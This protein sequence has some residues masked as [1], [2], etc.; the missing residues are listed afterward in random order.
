MWWNR[1]IWLLA[2]LFAIPILWPELLIKRHVKAPN[3][4]AALGHTTQSKKGF[5]RLSRLRAIAV[6]AAILALAGTVVFI[7]TKNRRIV[8]LLDLSASIS[9]AQVEVSRR[10]LL[11]LLGRLNPGDRAAVVTFASEPQLTAAFETPQRLGALLKTAELKAPRTGATN[12]EAAVRLGSRMLGDAG[13]NRCLLLLSDG[14]PTAGGTDLAAMARDAGIPIYTLGVGSGGGSL[15]T[16]ELKVPEV[17]H[18]RERVLVRWEVDSDRER[19]VIATIRLNQRTIGR[20]RVRLTAG[21]NTVLLPVQVQEPGIHRFE[22][23]VSDAAGKIQSQASSA[24]LLQ[25]TGPARVLVIHG[26]SSNSP[27]TRV[28]TTQ[29]MEVTRQGAAGIPENS[30]GLVGYGAV[31]LD[32]VPALYINEAQ[33]NALQG[34]VAGGGGLLVVGGDASLGRGEYYATG[35][36][37]L[38]PV[39]TDTRQRLFFNRANIL[40]VID[41]SGSMSEMVG[42]TSKQ[43]AAMQG[44][45]AA[46]EELNPQDQVGILSF[47]VEATWVLRF[48]P[49]RQKNLIR[50]ALSRIGQGGG[51]DMSTAMEE[52]V[53]GFATV[54]PVR[55]HVVILSDGQTNNAD[56]NRICRKLK[57]LGVTI[58]TIGIGEEVNEPL[59]KDIARWG[60][61]Q[62]YRAQLDQIPKV[63]RKETVR[64]TRDLI[65]EGIFYPQIKTSAP[66]LA[67]TAWNR[68]PVKGYLI[69]KPKSLATVFLGIGKNDPLL[70]SWRY[71]NGKVAVFTSDSGNRW[72]A[73]WSG[74]SNYNQLW[75]QTIRSV[76]RA[77]I[78]TGLMVT[79]RAEAATAVVAVE[80]IGTDRRLR[81]GLQLT[82]TAMD[83]PQTGTTN[84]E[85]GNSTGDNFVFTETAPGH[86]EAKV[87]L[88]SSGL[89][90]F[91]VREEQS[92]DWSVGWLWNPPGL[93]MLSSGPDRAFLENIA[94]ATGGGLLTVANPVLPTPGWAWRKVS[95]HN[96]LILFALLCFLTE[97]G[98]RSTSLGQVTMARAVFSAWWEGQRR[99]IEMIRGG[100]KESEEREKQSRDNI[101]EAY[102]YLAERARRQREEEQ[103]NA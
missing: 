60:D 48:T 16:R 46:I 58:T 4:E 98:I 8:A 102:R 73:A 5:R 90:Q 23:Q 14:R 21:R 33:Q 12:L 41:H 47:D 96:W 80:A 51:T 85:T 100:R 35:L 99:I 34:F 17:I 103:K 45:A 3:P 59:L 10:A 30:G 6:C 62:Y 36:E 55:R 101:Y 22:I 93:E 69:T 76:E 64:V 67:G 28:L 61:G 89:K 70:A 74:S 13:G 39:Q 88:T 15:I 49:A 1:P 75:S 7:P 87:P 27:L 71:G 81:S 92:G 94:A 66:F 83:E 43:L 52:V 20:E 29:G 53:K 18:L 44:V 38:L 25:V 9:P 91:Q 72:L 57:N 65:Q 2:I 82:G 50:S 11:D 77:A 86:Y 79:A 19:E 54:G 95:L 97:L 32:N 56:F 84:D 24:G 31:V 26:D 42:K 68:L 63:I 37:D 78:D 40:F